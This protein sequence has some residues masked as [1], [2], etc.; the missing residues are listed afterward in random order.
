MKYGRFKSLIIISTN[1]RLAL[2][3]LA[4]QK[5]LNAE[6]HTRPTVSQQICRIEASTNA[7]L[8]WHKRG[9]PPS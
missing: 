1:K 7:N 6:L 9:E 2:S 3:T 4:P 8:P 5:I